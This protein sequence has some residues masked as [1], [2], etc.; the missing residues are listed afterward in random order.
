MTAGAQTWRAVGEMQFRYLFLAVLVFFLMTCFDVFRLQ[1]LTA[2]LGTRLSFFYGLKTVLS[3]YFLSSITP[4]VTGGEPLMVYMLKEKG[5]SLGKGTAIVVI[6]GILLIFFIAMGGPLI[7]YFHHELIPNAGM[8]VLF[9][10]V[11]WFLLAAIIFL[12]YTLYNPKRGEKWIEKTLRFLERFSY[13]K[14]HSHHIA[15]KID[16]WIDELSFSFKF[17]IKKKK[18]RLFWATVWTIM[19]MICNYSLAY[20]ILKGLNVDV[21]IWK[22]LMV[23]IVLYFL[24][25]FCPSPG[26]TGFVEGGYYMLFAPFVPLH[27]LGIMIILLRFFSTYLGVFLGGLVIMKTFGIDRLEGFAEEEMKP[28]LVIEDENNG[29]CSVQPEPVEVKNE[30]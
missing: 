28:V 13:F 30:N 27:L 14:K 17:F 25:Y 6:R 26:G 2:G 9:D 21:S 15:Q 1:V 8:R 16:D 24:L 20:I 29:S 18:N 19:F 23:Q 12:S 10:F 11:A 22:V 7:I 4:T 3:Y 5:V